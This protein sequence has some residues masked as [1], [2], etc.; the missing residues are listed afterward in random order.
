MILLSLS[1]SVANADSLVCSLKETA[2]PKNLSSVEVD[3]S[4]LQEDFYIDDNGIDVGPEHYNFNM[5]VARD[6][7]KLEIGVI[8][9]EN[10]RVQD[11]VANGS[12][13]I[14]LIATKPGHPV[15]QEDLTDDSNN[16]LLDFVC[17]YNR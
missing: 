6:G 7:Q 5:Q 8:F 12:W 9:Y 11:E 13:T 10:N 16:K 1:A 15:L 17:E 2:N 4:Q 14:D 3:L